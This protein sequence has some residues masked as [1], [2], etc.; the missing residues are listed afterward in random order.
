[1]GSNPILSIE[2]FIGFNLL[3]YVSNVR[4]FINIFIRTDTFNTFEYM[5]LDYF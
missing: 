5:I 3:K 4:V 1:M 2:I